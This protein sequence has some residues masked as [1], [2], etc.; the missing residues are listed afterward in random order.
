ME[1]EE[2]EQPAIFQIGKT[3]YSMINITKEDGE[4]VASIT[5]DNIITKKGFNVDLVEDASKVRFREME[6]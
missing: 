6:D 1:Q 2:K 4:L 3:D 5:S